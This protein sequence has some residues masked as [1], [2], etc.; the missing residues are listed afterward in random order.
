MAGWRSVVL[1]QQI[2]VAIRVSRG[3]D[4]VRGI[5]PVFADLVDHLS[6]HRFFCSGT[7]GPFSLKYRFFHLGFRGVPSTDGTRRWVPRMRVVDDRIPARKP[8][9]SSVANRRSSAAAPSD[10]WLVLQLKRRPDN[11]DSRDQCHADGP[12]RWARMGGGSVVVGIFVSFPSVPVRLS[13]RPKSAL[14]QDGHHS[15]S[16]SRKAN[17]FFRR[18]T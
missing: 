18:S 16:C 10:L 12:W 17:G 14:D 5:I 11:Q 2:R 7:L 6:V 4:R 8:P 3:R 15:T 13:W 1:F 9:G